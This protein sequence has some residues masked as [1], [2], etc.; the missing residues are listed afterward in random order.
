MIEKKKI[1]VVDDSGIM[2]RLIKSWLEEKYQVILAN[3][4]AMALKYLAANTPDLILLDYEMPI[5]TGYEVLEKIITETGAA[6]I[7]VLFLTSK[8]DIEDMM[9]GKTFVAQGYISKTM[10][11][12]KIIM[13]VD[14]VLSAKK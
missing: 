7:P 6:D 4:G 11:P 5:M 1:L 12:D 8:T 13:I 2:L 10:E 3:S 14:N 9:K